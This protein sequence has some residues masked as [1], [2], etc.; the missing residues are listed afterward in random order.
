[1]APGHGYDGDTFAADQVALLDALEIESASVIGHDW[2]GWTAF[3]LG[4]DH[5]ERIERMVVCNAPHPWP[6][7]EPSLLLETWRSW[8][9][10]TNAT[11]VLGKFLMQT[12]IPELILGHGNV[13]DPFSEGFD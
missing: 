13:G 12:R 6:K 9:A 8:Y 11:P 5:A 4:I 1:E 10:L 2:G 7:V 3:L